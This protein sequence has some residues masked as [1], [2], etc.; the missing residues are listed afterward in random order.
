MAILA[1]DAM[2]SLAFQLIAEAAEPQ[3]T[4]RL[5]S[6]LAHAT[7]PQGMIGGQVLDI[8]SENTALTLD[9]LKQVHRLKTGALLTT[10]CRLGALCA[11]ASGT[12]LSAITE[13][14]RHIGLAFQIVDD[15]LDVTSTPEQM[16]KATNKDQSKGKNTYPALIGLE[17]SQN[18]ARNEVTSALESLE[19]LGPSADGLRI[20]ARFV[21]DRQA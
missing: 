4:P 9:Q 13:F 2:V 15:V 5:I 11:H 20:L 3:L 14:G 12:Q 10:S 21:T 18:Q 8:D 19:P 17:A 1:G 7:G 6:E 16:G